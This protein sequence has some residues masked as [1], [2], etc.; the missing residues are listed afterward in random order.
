MNRF[1]SVLLAFVVSSGVFFPMVVGA[2]PKPSHLGQAVRVGQF[3]VEFPI[4]APGIPVIRSGDDNVFS[5]QNY[6]CLEVKIENA[7]NEN[8]QTEGSDFQL[9][10]KPKGGNTEYYTIDMAESYN[11]DTATFKN[12]HYRFSL[13]TLHTIK[14]KH[15]D[16]MLL[17]FDIPNDISNNSIGTIGA[18]LDMSASRQQYWD[19][20]TVG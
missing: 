10:W 18:F 16:T 19:L 3:I 17:V 9:T 6:F 20:A 12:G 4:K 7:T 14:P 1:T 2:Y 11:L 15:W 13:P 5:Y 8:W